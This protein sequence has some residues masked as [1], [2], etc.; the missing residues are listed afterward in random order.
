MQHPNTQQFSNGQ[1]SQQ[2]ILTTQQIHGPVTAADS[3]HNKL[4]AVTV[5][6]TATSNA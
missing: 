2:Q 3:Q 4:S 5:P 6:I 1:Q